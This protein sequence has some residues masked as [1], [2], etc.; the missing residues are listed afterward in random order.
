[1]SSTSRLGC[2]GGDLPCATDASCD[3]E[4]DRCDGACDAD[5]D[6]FESVACG[7]DDC[8]DSDRNRYPGNVELCDSGHDEDCD[9]ETVGPD[10][11]GD[12]DASILCCNG[13]TCGSDCDD[14]SASVFAGATEICNERDD[15]CDGRVDEGV[16]RTLYEDLDGDSYGVTERTVMACAAGPGLALLPGD[17]DDGLSTV[18][19]GAP[20][21]CDGVDN[22][23]DGQTDDVR[24]D[25]VI[26]TVDET[27]AC[28]T[29]CGSPGTALCTACLGFSQCIGEEACNDC[30]DDLDGDSDEGFECRQGQVQ[31]CATACGTSGLSTCDDTCS[32][33]TACFATSE[34]CNYCDDNGEN[35]INDERSLAAANGDRTFAC[36]ASAGVD[37]PT[38]VG[39]GARCVT[40]PDDPRPGGTLFA[41]DTYAQIL[42]GSSASQAGAAWFVPDDFMGWG[43]IELVVEAEVRAASA[44]GAD[45]EGGWAIVFAGTGGG[46]GPADRAG[47]PTA[48]A[49]IGVEWT[50][51]H[52][53]EGEYA[54][55]DA[56]R[57]RRLPSFAALG[58]SSD[59]R[60]VDIPNSDQD[61]AGST[62]WVRQR[63]TLRYTPD[64]PT[65]GANEERLQVRSGASTWTTITPATVGLRNTPLTNELPPGSRLSVGVTAGVTNRATEF[66]VRILRLVVEDFC[67]GPPPEIRTYPTQLSRALICP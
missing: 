4:T 62:S 29:T 8:D 6:G 26:C 16:L 59:F 57:A 53:A 7:G 65:T 33:P 52:V 64:D 48:G 15:D 61:Y 54:G 37:V 23:C 51:G 45:I 27:T 42:D 1:M 49:G 19:E 35:G 11:D 34:S 13:D 39:D 22:D 63:M 3:E 41:G 67:C 24:D 12:G 10:R 14:L 66:R 60:Y 21:T 18:Y 43:T 2:V 9:P 46:V 55:G 56:Y 31:V 32:F 30:D 50:W 25:R 28:E 20:E 17:C 36:A 5:G 38:L 44:S 47:V 58:I 40:E